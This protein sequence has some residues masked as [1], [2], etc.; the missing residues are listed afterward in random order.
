M[1]AAIPF[2]ALNFASGATKMSARTYFSATLVGI[3]PGVLVYSYAGTQ[4]GDATRASD[5]VSFQVVLALI[6]ISLLPLVGKYLQRKY[7]G[8]ESNGEV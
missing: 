6:G 2:Y 1:N 7:S 3:T 5:V 4:L 8:K